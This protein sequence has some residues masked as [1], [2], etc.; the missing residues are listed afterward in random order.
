MSC[1]VNVLYTDRWFQ[2][3]P[4]AVHDMGESDRK[5]IKAY[6]ESGITSCGLAANPTGGSLP[7][8]R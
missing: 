6:W 3:N 5:P 2:T 1:P 7:D 4:F 8:P